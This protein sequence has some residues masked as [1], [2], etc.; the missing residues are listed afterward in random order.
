M[1]PR[2]H[3]FRRFWI[4]VPHLNNKAGV[5]AEQPYPNE[6][7]VIQLPPARMFIHD[8]SSL[9][10]IGDQLGHRQ[11]RVVLDKAGVPVIQGATDVPV[12]AGA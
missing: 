12:G 4:A 9:H 3:Q 11:E 7:E 10:G 6:V 1:P 5:H 8:A 2:I